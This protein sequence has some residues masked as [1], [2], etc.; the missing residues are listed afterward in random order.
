MARSHLETRRLLLVPVTRSDADAV[1]SG[2]RQS[3][4]SEGYPTE[5]DVEI[6]QMM[7]KAAAD[8]TRFDLFGPFNVVE[9]E[10]GMVIG[11]AGFLGPPDDQGAVEIGYGLAPERRNRGLATEAVF[12]LLA[13]AWSE[14]SVQ[15]VFAT[16]DPA[17]IA[18]AR[19]LEKAGLSRVRITNELVY[20]ESA[21][22]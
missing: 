20:Y 7:A 22:P 1:L 15:R 2:V 16:T 8:S 17:N 13:F 21:R 6:A 10:S 19:V 3:N 12:G 14:P 11:G 18:S 4:W 9:R 5:G